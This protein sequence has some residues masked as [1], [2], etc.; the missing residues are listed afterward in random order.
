MSAQIIDGK[1]LAAKIR[2]QIATEVT[3]LREAQGIVPGLAV[4]LVGDNE[5][6]KI[7]VRNKERAATQAGLPRV[8]ARNITEKHDVFPC[9][10]R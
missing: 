6:S 3:A 10:R 4:V 2:A 8:L 5:G 9:H 7:Y 1:G